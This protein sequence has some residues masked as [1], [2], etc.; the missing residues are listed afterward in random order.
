MAKCS[1]LHMM[2]G[3][4]IFQLKNNL[5]VLKAYFCTFC[6]QLFIDTSIPLDWVLMIDTW[7][8]IQL[9]F[10]SSSSWNTNY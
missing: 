4:P 6:I 1:F 8:D 5:S 7:I 3:K 9:Y 10:E 2:D